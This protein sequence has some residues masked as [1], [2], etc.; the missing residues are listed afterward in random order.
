MAT[1]LKRHL[2]E[3]E[4]RTIKESF[5]S[6]IV[7]PLYGV[8]TDLDKN[9][10]D[11]DDG[12]GSATSAMIING[13]LICVLYAALPPEIQMKAFASKPKGCTRKIILATNIAETSGT[14]IFSSFFVDEFFFWERYIYIFFKLPLVYYCFVENLSNFDLC[15]VLKN[16]ELICIYFL[17]LPLYLPNPVTLDGIRYVIDCGK[18]KTREFS[19]TTGMES[20]TVQD[21]SQAQVRNAKKK[22]SVNQPKKM[23]IEESNPTFFLSLTLFILTVLYPGSTT[24]RTC[25]SC[26]GWCLFSIIYRRCI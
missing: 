21:I 19:G 2:R 26:F 5:T 18:H 7:Q 3:E 15:L 6:D 11:D 16:L 17:L 25:W 1:L 8:G 12:K 23:K 10:D 9:D 22:I 13:V 14:C 24:C 4:E 20:L